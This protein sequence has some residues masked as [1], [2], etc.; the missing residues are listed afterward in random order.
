MNRHFTLIALVACA[1]LFPRATLAQPKD[2]PKP[3]PNAA[4]FD[5]EAVAADHPLASAAG[6][7]ILAAGGNAVDAAVAT[8]FALSVVRPFSCGIGGGGFMVIVLPAREGK[9]GV[10]TAINYRETCPGGRR[11]G[12]LR[13]DG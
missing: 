10:T 13:E 3:V 2:V 6:A 5:R 1:A 12:L 4:T 9:P 8:S 11:A 7:E